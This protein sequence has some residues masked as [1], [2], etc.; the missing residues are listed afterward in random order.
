MSKRLHPL[1][2]WY[3]DII[4]FSCFTSVIMFWNM[5]AKFICLIINAT[6]CMKAITYLR[7][8]FIYF[9]LV[10]KA[11]PENKSCKNENHYDS[12]IF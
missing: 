10:A 7:L 8:K 9:S 5:Y 3:F 12:K 4:T 2:M 6:N 1:V 11:V